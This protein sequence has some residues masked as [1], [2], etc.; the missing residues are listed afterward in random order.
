[1]ISFKKAIYLMDIHII[2]FDNIW[3]KSQKEN[4]YTVRPNWKLLQSKLQKEKTQKAQK[5]KLLKKW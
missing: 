4:K 3:S 5:R 2:D 1:M